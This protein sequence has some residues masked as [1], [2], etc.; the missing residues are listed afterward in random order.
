[1]KLFRLIKRLPLAP[2]IAQVWVAAIFYIALCLGVAVLVKQQMDWY[3][4]ASQSQLNASRKSLAVDLEKAMEASNSNLKQALI[5]YLNHPENKPNWVQDYQ[6][7]DYDKGWQLDTNTGDYQQL[8]RALDPLLSRPEASHRFFEAIARQRMRAMV[9][10]EQYGTGEINRSSAFRLHIINVDSL[11][12][13]KTLLTGPL[14][15]QLKGEVF[16]LTHEDR[17]VFS[18][19]TTVP[20][21]QPEVSLP[22][23]ENYNLPLLQR[24]HGQLFFQERGR[25]Q[26]AQRANQPRRSRGKGGTFETILSS[27]RLHVASV[28]NPRDYILHIY[29]P[30]LPLQAIADRQR[31]R[32][33]LISSTVLLLLTLVAA[34]LFRATRQAQKFQQLER[35]FVASMNHEL[36]TPLTVIRSAADNLKD[37]IVSKPADIANYGKVLSEQSQRLERMINSTL[38]FAK[39]S[40]Q[41]RPFLSEVEPTA[42]FNEVIDPLRQLCEDQNIVF[43]THFK[44]L[45]SASDQR[46]EIDATAVRLV[47]ENLVM[48][49][50]IHARPDHGLQSITLDIVQ[51][52]GLLK[53]RVRDNGPGISKRER[54]QI[55]KAFVRGERSEAEQRPG[56]GLGLNLVQKTVKRLDGQVTLESPYMDQAGIKQQG[57]QF[58]VTLPIKKEPISAAAKEGYGESR[59]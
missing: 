18:S 33:T 51:D 55:F 35:E 10:I 32:S 13:V 29:H 46:L 34:M 30:E 8:I 54:R 20:Q 24:V 5:T 44:P 11:T 27:L 48:N 59:V 57:A 50:L 25:V 9:L 15:Q 53:I 41:S 52:D 16:T 22:L 21:Y 42:F 49:A 38:Y 1:M 28:N 14:Q 12:L 56:S 4:H 31:L 43:K 17:V 36:R 7:L 23:L 19:D 40:S 37:G 58:L 3:A 47:I 6:I 45:Y 26:G 2:A 39:E